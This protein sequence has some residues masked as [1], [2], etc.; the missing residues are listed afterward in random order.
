MPNGFFATRMLGNST[1]RKINFNK[2]ANLGIHFIFGSL[3][4]QPVGNLVIAPLLSSEAG[5]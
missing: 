3:T 1:Y 4:R 5:L 2:P